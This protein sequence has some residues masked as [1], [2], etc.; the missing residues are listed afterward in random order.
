MENTHYN[1][2]KSL[3]HRLLAMAELTDRDRD[4]IIKE[5][6]A[7][8]LD[9]QEKVLKPKTGFKDMLRS[10]SLE[11]LDLKRVNGLDR[12]DVEFD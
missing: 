7:K 1:L 9:E 11:D 2:G 6:V 10:W 3:E 5:A 12:P 4:D 8:H